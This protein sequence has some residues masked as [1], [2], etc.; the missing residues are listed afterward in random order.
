M[1][2]I[3]KISPKHLS[4]I[5]YVYIRQSTTYQVVSNTESTL[6]QYALRERL[7]SLGWDNSLIQVIDTDLGISGKSSE[8]REGFM[9]LMADVA[10]GK[11]GAIACIEASRLSRCSADWSRLIEICT[12]TETLLI[13]TD[14]I[15]NPNDFNDRLLLGLKG[16]MSEAELHFLQER[17]RGGL[18]NKAKRGELK[19]YLPIGY[20]YDCDDNI[21][22]TPDIRIREAVEQFFELFRIKKTGSSVVAY[23]T[24]NE[25][26]F[27]VRQRTKGHMHEVRWEIMN[28]E[29][30]IAMLHNPFYTGAYI[31]GRTQ[32]KWTAAGKRRPMPV[33]EDEW[34]VNIPDHHEAY[35]SKEEFEHNQEILTQNTQQWGG[36]EKKTSPREGS[37]LLQ[38][39]C[40]CGYCGYR[41]TPVCS[42][43][44]ATGRKIMRYFCS[45]KS[46]DGGRS[47]C[48]QSLPADVID[49]A[50]SRIVEEKLT[51]EALSLTVQ[52]KEEVSRR[53]TDRL[54]F[55][56]LQLENA[57][58][59][60]SVAR[61]RYMSVDP[62][63]RLVALQLET[64]WNK[65]I[66]MYEEA[67]ARYD[68]ELSKAESS[69]NDELKKAA[70]TIGN[71][72]S[73]VWNNPS[74]RNEDKKRILRYV[75]KD[76]TLLR[77]DSYSA[78]IG[79]CF[80]G[81][82]TCEVEVQ[83]PKPRYVCITTP[84]DVLEFMENNAD[85]YTYTQ[86]AE[87]L[88]D[89]GLFR[90]C[91]RPFNRSNVFRIMK[92]YGIK[93]KKQRYID[94]GWLTI[95][96]AAKALG[97]TTP[98]LRYRIKSGIYTGKTVIVEESGTLLLDPSAIQTI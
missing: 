51:P 58:H 74:V 18:L 70:E 30:A 47:H 56:E 19:R 40:Y 4:R 38:G 61:M 96:D 85:E 84:K 1:E 41:M 6:R 35:I 32:M 3:S 73:K 88:N 36:T 55:F 15:Y 25:I 75:I 34:H 64:E 59:E 68:E 21:V 72:F 44:Q 17:M 27:P 65:K 71:N 78:K 20:E 98:A 81:G 83:V 62:A 8:N 12:M 82:T 54:R 93:S 37:A 43:S 39:I 9:K 45:G 48:R 89:S 53:K 46:K 63:N 67:A 87:K 52:V 90:E 79:I 5:G 57:K 60:E 42:K 86:M 94:R 80:Q 13:D 97:L 14:G 26:T 2:G 22:K 91:G 31:Y 33:S 16:T 23:Y 10:N 29:R 77:T 66:R 24:E 7:A 95:K 92:D 76:A 11:V 69:E 50:V 49:A 28:S